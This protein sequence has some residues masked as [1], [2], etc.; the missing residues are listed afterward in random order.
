M[1][2]Q[3]GVGAA[4]ERRRIA[5]VGRLARREGED[6]QDQGEDSESGEDQKK[7]EAMSVQTEIA[8]Q[9]TSHLGP[10]GGITG[11]TELGQGALPAPQLPQ[12]SRPLLSDRLLQLGLA[13]VSIPVVSRHT[14]LAAIP[15]ALL[16]AAACRSVPLR[17]LLTPSGIAV[18]PVAI[19][20]FFS[21][22]VFI[23]LRNM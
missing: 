10:G 21:C 22:S 5:R 2:A 13:A 11:R 17:S 7:L 19:G 23:T 12:E 8:G 15:A 16:T 14:Y 3:P 6:E 4:P 9:V 18:A 20:Y 1:E